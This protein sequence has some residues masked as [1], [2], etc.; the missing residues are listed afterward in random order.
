MKRTRHLNTFTATHKASSG[1][2]KWSVVQ[3]LLSVLYNPLFW[4]T[5]YHYIPFQV[6]GFRNSSSS[7]QWLSVVMCLA[8]FF[9]V[10]G[11]Q[12]VLCT[13]DTQALPRAVCLHHPGLF[14]RSWP[15]WWCG[16]G[17]NVSG[18][19]WST[20]TGLPLPVAPWGN[21]YQKASE[22]LEALKPVLNLAKKSLL[23]FR[24]LQ[25]LLWFEYGLS[26]KGLCVRWLV[27]LVMMLGNGEAL[28]G[29]A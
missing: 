14:V 1:H 3:W 2:A 13:F 25:P 18:T 23:E 11:R 27:T 8:A 28:R 10:L 9:T 17:V 16:R 19:A 12:P 20:P 26:P 7:N 21:I 15:L 24:A 4:L 22:F 5:K 6:T 29:G